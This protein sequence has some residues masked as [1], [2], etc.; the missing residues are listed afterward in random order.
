MRKGLRKAG[1]S[2][3]EGHEN[4]AM[5]RK[6]NMRAGDENWAGSTWS[7]ASWAGGE[8]HGLC[9]EGNE[10]PLRVSKGVTLSDTSYEVPS[11]E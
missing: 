10:E 2:E 4:V 3:R 11:A 7:E 9:A 1:E 8:D 6:L 5:A